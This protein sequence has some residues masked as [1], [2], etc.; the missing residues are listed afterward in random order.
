[1]PGAKANFRPQLPMSL[2][3]ESEGYLGDNERESELGR[4]ATMAEERP[5]PVPSEQEVSDI[6]LLAEL[7]SQLTTHRKRRE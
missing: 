7:A 6:P 3:R 4:V 1:M 2:P 5:S